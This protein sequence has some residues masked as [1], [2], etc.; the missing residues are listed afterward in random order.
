[1]EQEQH[2]YTIALT[3]IPNVGPITA[4][5]L[6]SYCG[7]PKAVFFEK[8][9]RLLSIPGV[10]DQTANNITSAEVLH[11]A[12]KDYENCI[13]NQAAFLSYLDAEYPSRLKAIADSPIIL[14]YKGNQSLNPDRALAIVGTRKISPYGKE[15]VHQIVRDLAQEQIMI[16]SG[17]AYGVDTHA[18]KASVEH[19][20][21]TIAV[22]AHGIESIYPADNT[23]LAQQ[24]ME[25]G[26]ILT[27][28]P[29]GSIPD[30][31]H[32]PMRNRIVA[33]MTDATLV[34]ETAVDG[35]SMITATFA[36]EYHKDVLA[37]PG[38]TTDSMSEGCN[39]L[40]KT[41]RAQ[42]IENA[43]DILQALC[44]NKKSESVKPKRS[45]FLELSEDEQ[46]V[47]NIIKD[48]GEIHVDAL[49]IQAQFNSGKLASTILQLELKSAVNCLP[50]KRYS[51]SL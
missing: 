25:N 3:K 4:K 5:N 40:I 37:L 1:M 38:R 17:L 6:V 16:V 51:V 43:E 46:I 32:F 35:G 7:S 12:E 13:K 47:F 31:E 30:K 15:M 50:G 49:Q 44:W 28:Y 42:L 48:A 23:K 14:Y 29:V 34:I 36:N 33:G 21:P 2:L 22:L 10:G 24:M 39:L 45:L 8:K 20:L 9:H 26:G 18:H 11:E 27:E 19:G 41:H